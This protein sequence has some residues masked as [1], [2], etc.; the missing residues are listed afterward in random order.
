[1][2]QKILIIGIVSLSAI[3]CKKNYNCV[4]TTVYSGVMQGTPNVTQTTTID[5]TKTNA[6]VQCNDKAGSVAG[7]STT[8]C[9]LQ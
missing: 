6:T 2:K 3:S 4:C 1:M 8:T 7:G 5:D 9:V